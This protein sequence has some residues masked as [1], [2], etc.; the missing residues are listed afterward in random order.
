[1]VKIN[2]EFINQIIT[3]KYKDKIFWDDD[4]KGFGIR[5]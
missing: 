5:V 4:L 3:K 1:M 2:K